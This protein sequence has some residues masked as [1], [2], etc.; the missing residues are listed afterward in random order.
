MLLCL[1][2]TSLSG[3]AASEEF[4]P[5]DLAHHP[6]LAA[7]LRAEGYTQAARVE[8]YVVLTRRAPR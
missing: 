7:W 5:Y 4:D 2:Y 1:L 8:N 6:P 3:L